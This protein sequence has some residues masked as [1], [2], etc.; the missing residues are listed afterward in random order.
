MKKAMIIVNRKNE[1]QTVTLDIGVS[2]N[3][4]S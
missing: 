1:L 2:K 3:L 4:A